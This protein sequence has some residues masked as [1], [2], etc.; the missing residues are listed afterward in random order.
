MV[1][2]ISIIGWLVFSRFVPH[3]Y[4]PVFPFVVLLYTLVSISI[5][6][7][8]LKLAKKNMGKFTRSI[9]AITFL[10]IILYSAVAIFYI[11]IDKE[12]AKTF[13]VVF[14]S[15]YVVFLVFEVF[16]LLRITQN[17]NKNE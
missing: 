12:N 5:H 1:L 11:A 2:V 14:L 10:K 15:L 8:Q 6:A 16:S 7:F 13:V 9:M 3:Y 4:L 17:S